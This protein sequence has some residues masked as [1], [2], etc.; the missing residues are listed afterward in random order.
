M[1]VPLSIA[2]PAA[3]SSLAYLNARISLSYD[4]NLISN[5]LKARARA[6]IREHRDRV[7]IFYVLEE[8]AQ[9]RYADRTFMVYEGKEW[10]FKQ[11]YETVLK[12]G[13]WL[14]TKHG[15]KPRE[16]VAMDFMNSPT[17][18][19]LWLGLWSIGAQPAFINYNLTGKP[20]LHCVKTST[21][22]LLLVDAELTTLTQEVIDAA[23]STN[24]RGPGQGGVE[25]VT[26]TADVASEVLSTPGFRA[27]DSDREGRL[28]SDLGI[29]IYTSGTTGL[30]KPAIVSWNK[31]T[32]GSI[33]TFT[34]MGLK[35]DDRMYT[36]CPEPRDH[37]DLRC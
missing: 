32:L 21:A 18:A 19:F 34:W 28:L 26:F 12:Y 6:K 11:M 31:C 5:L 15:V 4:W 22:R 10:S 29:L 16:I 35:R 13:A 8:H 9:S 20:L 17:F 30:P 3:I 25:I 1:A 7:N 37:P 33:F 24:F 23:S 36:V 14:K 27:P 2:V